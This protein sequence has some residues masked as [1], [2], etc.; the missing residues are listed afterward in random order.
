MGPLRACVA[1][2]GSE[3]TGNLF[4]A[5]GLDTQESPLLGYQAQSDL[6]WPC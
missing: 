3:G 1:T 5:S 2:L 4:P 6:W